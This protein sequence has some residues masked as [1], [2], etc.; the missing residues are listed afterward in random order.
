MLTTEMS[1]EYVEESPDAALNVYYERVHM[2]R[3]VWHNGQNRGRRNHH[4]LKST[5][6][7]ESML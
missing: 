4:D 3:E 6:I 7:N 2:D 5:A 1:I